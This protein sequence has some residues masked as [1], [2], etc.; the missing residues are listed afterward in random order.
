MAAPISSTKK[1]QDPTLPPATCHEEYTEQPAHYHLPVLL[2]PSF[3]MQVYA[4]GHREV[5][6]DIV[7]AW[8]FPS[9]P[10]GD[11]EKSPDLETFKAILDGLYLLLA[12][13]VWSSRCKLQVLDLR[14]EHPEI[15]M[16]GYPSIAQISYPAFLTDNLTV[17]CMTE[18]QTLIIAMAL[19]IKNGT[20]NDLQAFLLQSVRERKGLVQ[21]CSRKLQ[22]LSGSFSM[23]HSILFV[24]CL[25]S[26]QELVLNSF[27]HRVTMKNFA[28]Y[29]HMMKNLHTV[30]F[31]K[32]S[33]NFY[34]S[35]SRNC[36]YP[37]QLGAHLGQ[38]QHLQE[39]HVHDVFFLYKQ[40][41]AICGS[42]RPLKA[43][44]LS[45]CPLKQAD[46]RILSQCLCTRQFNHLWLRSLCMDRVSHELLSA[47]LEHVAG[48][49]CALALEDCDITDSQLSNIMPALSQCS[50]HRFFSFP[51]N[52]ISMASLQNLLS[53]MVS[54]SHLR[55]G[56]YP[57]PLESYRHTGNIQPERF[58][59]VRAGLAQRL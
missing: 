45:S 15:W 21:L 23:I 31:S 59:R 58:A 14:N 16:W 35:T 2:F 12:K 4:R 25:N 5:L 44:S 10:M 43:L 47:L 33:F 54:L 18:E 13:K 28:P 9:L 17:N 20:Q 40:L 3:F 48:T 24:V 46:M 49:L 42:L 57:G 32:M 29:L 52:F 39:L 27:W 6:K 55:Q 22:I 37:F 34:T 8:P 19:T 53:H 56:L 50:Q 26:I 38:L 7:K 36:P 51:G 41:R 1:H 30:N 11:R